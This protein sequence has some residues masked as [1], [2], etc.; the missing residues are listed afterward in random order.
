[1]RGCLALLG[2][3]GC[4]ACAT[5][6]APPPRMSWNEAGF[7]L[8]DEAEES[9]VSPT[10]GV[11]PM[12]EAAHHLA[13]LGVSVL[14][15]AGVERILR[16]QGHGRPMPPDAQRAWAGLFA[17]IDQTV[18]G[19]LPAIPMDLIRARV[20]ADAE[21]SMD[22]AAYA[23][24]PREL[25]QAVRAHMHALTVRLHGGNLGQPPPSVLCWPLWPVTVSSLYG[26]RLDPIDHKTWKRHEGIDLSAEPGQLVVASAKGVVVDAG[27]RAG[28][29]LAV[30]LRHDDGTLT[31][32][33]HLSQILTQQ[34]LMIERGGA[35]GLVGSTGR[36]TGPHLHF[37]IWR[38][39]RTWDPL[40]ELGDPE[41]NRPPEM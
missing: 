34:G 3:L 16:G 10:E 18:G 19:Q 20:A 17:A 23:S 39:G 14:R 35:V 29:G 6:A 38:D 4:V 36:S 30:T 24:V 27:L 1:M 11:G 41:L 22:Q 5:A 21:L 31:R 40:E 12:P 26:P 13:P 25:E 9:A 8:A 33:G 28:Y 7:D 2:A 37:E 32:Y 15:F